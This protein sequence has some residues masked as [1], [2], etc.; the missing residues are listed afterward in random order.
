MS[1]GEKAESPTYKDLGRKV[2]KLKRKL[3]RQLKDSQRREITRIKIAKL[4]NQI[5]DTR[6]D[7]LHKLS[8]QIV[9]ENQVIV[10]KT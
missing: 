2:R 6:Q 3:T 4:H 5:A 8:T 7:F 10:W 1:N 9:S